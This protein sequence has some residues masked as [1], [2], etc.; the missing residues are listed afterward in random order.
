MS[1]DYK[2]HHYKSKKK[3]N[4]KQEELETKYGHSASLFVVGSFGN[5]EFIVLEPN[6]LEVKL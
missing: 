1:E 6:N 3:A 5:E 4:K 2:E